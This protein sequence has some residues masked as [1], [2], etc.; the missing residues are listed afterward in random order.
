MGGKLRA[1]STII[2]LFPNDIEYYY[3]PFAGSASIL[4]NE[5]RSEIEVINDKDVNIALLHKTMA[6]REKGKQLV[7]VLLKQGCSR[8]AFIKAQLALKYNARYLDDVERSRCTFVT[9]TQS[10]NADRISAKKTYNNREYRDDLFYQLPKIYERYEGVRVRNECG[11]ELL[12]RIINNE[13]AFAFIDPPYVMRYRGNKNIYFCEMP[14]S[15]QTKLLETIK[16]GKCKMML[17][18]YIAKEEETD[19]YSRVLLPCGWKRYKL[20]DL[21]KACQTSDTKDFGEEY[22][23]VNYSLP[24]HAKYVIDISTESSSTE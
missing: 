1:V 16:N 23:W 5:Y 20:M 18:G 14:D 15:L 19:F 13:K 12:K 22:I 17:C 7:D 4:L 11:I 2:P 9:I 8:D 10:F 6:D 24:H 3:E 21:L